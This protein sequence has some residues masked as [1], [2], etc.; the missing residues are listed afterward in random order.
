MNYYIVKYSGPFGFIKPWTAVR[1]IETFS[2][3]FLTESILVG[4]ERKLF[5]ELLKEVPE[6][7]YMKSYRLSY[8]QISGQQEQIQTR[9]WNATKQ[10]GS[11]AI[12]FERP[13]AIIVRGIMIN[14]MLLLA[15]EE[16]ELAERAAR[17]HVCLCRNEDILFPEEIIDVGKEEY[18]SDTERF[19]GFE[20]VF[21]KNEKSFLAG[22]NRQK[23]NEPMYG[24]L[25]TV[26]TPVKEI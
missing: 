26:G 4:I 14:P 20:L 12:L 15:F 18:E 16:K 7:H 9:G 10:K 21:E 6:V 1:D 23:N 25:K 13:T 5:P 8:E 11:K 24:W 17:Q 19:A 22:Y 2:Q 3:Q